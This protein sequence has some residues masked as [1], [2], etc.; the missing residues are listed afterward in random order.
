VSDRG[1]KLRAWFP[2]PFVAIVV[3]LLVLIVLTPNLLSTAAPS[4]GSLPTEAELI[5]DRALGDNVTHLYVRGLG[6][7]RYASIEVAIAPQFSWA[8][9]PPLANISFGAPTWWND[10]L[11]SALATPANPF[12]VNVTAVYIDAAGVRVDFV[13]T[14]AFDIAGGVLSEIAYFPPSAGIT[15]TPVAQ[16]PLPIL[17]TTV[18][19]GR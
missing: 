19:G 10:S 16:L 3:L 12:A 13:G 17:L 15:T 4:A 6:L 2:T 1:D 18:S 8:D 11:A 7:P 14:F 9:P 5:V